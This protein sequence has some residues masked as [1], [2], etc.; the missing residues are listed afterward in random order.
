MVARKLRTRV[1]LDTNVLVRNARANSDLSP[2]RQIIRLWLI[3]KQIQLIV[4]SELVVEY[5]EILKDV[6]GLTPVT[7][8]KW[9]IRFESDPRTTTAQL[10][11]RY[12]E[13]R[14]PDDN[15]LLATA[16]AGKADYLV[17]NDR[18]LLDLP[19][20]FRRTLPF[21]IVTPLQFLQ[22]FGD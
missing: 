16:L 3:K 6:L 15:L 21:A 13:S 4:S 10:G 19:S 9:S 7:L 17:T 22:E 11:R 18:D 8:Q 5:L 12:T 20:A 1:V 14:D 2:N